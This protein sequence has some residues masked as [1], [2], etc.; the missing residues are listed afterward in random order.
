MHHLCWNALIFTI[1]AVRKVWLV[2]NNAD[3]TI[4]GLNGGLEYFHFVKPFID[5]LCSEL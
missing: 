2:Q 4:V 5:R 1:F 3:K